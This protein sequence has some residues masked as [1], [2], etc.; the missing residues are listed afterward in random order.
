[1]SDSIHDPLF[2]GTAGWTIAREHAALF[3]AEGSHLERYA[4]LFRAVEINV[5]FYRLPMARTF[6]R[7][8]E[9]VPPDFRFSVKLSRS[10]THHTRLKDHGLL[11]PFLER[12]ELLGEKLGPI[13][14]QLPPNLAFDSGPVRE[15]FREFRR[16]H[17]GAIVCE[18]RH[19]SWF[20]PEVELVWDEFRIARVAADPARAPQADQP[21]GW[22]G[23]VYYRLHGSP[24]VYYSSYDEGYL[25][26]LARQLEEWRQLAPVWCIF[27]NTASGAAV[28]N[29]LT[30]QQLTGAGRSQGDQ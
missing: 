23:L 19:L 15:F 25:Q 29:G 16:Q 10:I 7:W 11:A 14:V 30:I 27:D 1:M 2:L 18:P 22:N 8:A 17:D 20:A 5:T 28:G 4:Q 9:T 6:L 26:E 24:R 13:L 12:V 3:P 21:G